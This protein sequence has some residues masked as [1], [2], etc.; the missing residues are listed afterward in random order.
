M[1]WNKI[2]YKWDSSIVYEYDN[3]IN[4]SP[5][6]DNVWKCKWNANV[7]DIKLNWIKHETI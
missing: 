2:E 3:T 5:F 6:Y 4:E 1:K 7:C